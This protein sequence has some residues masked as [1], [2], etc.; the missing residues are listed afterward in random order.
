MVCIGGKLVD[1]VLALQEGSH[2]FDRV[3]LAELLTV[4]VSIAVG[5][6]DNLSTQRG[7]LIIRGDIR[8]VLSNEDVR[9]D[10]PTAINGTAVGSVIL[11]TLVL[12]AILREELAM[13]VACQDVLFVVLVVASGIG[14]LD[15][16]S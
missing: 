4:L 13:L 2:L 9:G 5:E 12:D 8:G 1:D 7:L 10:A 16:A 15:A 3:Q 11:L 14:L 6:H